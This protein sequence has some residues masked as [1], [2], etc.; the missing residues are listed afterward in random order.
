LTV[1]PLRILFRAAAGPRTGF[2]HLVRCRSLAR[3]LGVN[4]RVS[5]RGSAATRA[6][7]AL[8]GWQVLESDSDRALRAIDPQ[9]LVVDDPSQQA[10]GIWVR[11]ARRL[12][13]RVSTIH[14]LGLGYVVSDLGIDGS[15]EP[16]LSMHGGYGDLRGPAHAIL[17]PAVASLRERHVDAT[18]N[19]ILIALGGGS[20]V[21]M[22]AARLCRALAA[23][24]P[25][26]TIRVAAGFAGFAHGGGRQP[27]VHGDWI[28]AP[29]GLATELA[30][31]SV[32]VVAGGVT[33]Y[34]ACALGVPAVAVAVTPAQ[35]VTIR[36]FAAHG[37]AI[38]GGV[39]GTSGCTVEGVAA[40]VGRLLRSRASCRRLA[41]AGQRLVDGRGAFRVGTA[42]R[43]LCAFTP[44][45]VSDAA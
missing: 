34:E 8:A 40:E 7:A 12:G 39:S 27:L 29:D 37:A 4:V 38:D 32:A 41:V 43:Q 22:F 1:S 14:D 36:A 28:H 13:I 45:G 5:I 25:D 24:V 21:F 3:A 44:P 16:R 35:H 31:A 10:A 19:Q 17:D 23:E 33:L 20:H 30:A 2:G 15:I 26:A 9:L 6:A 11:R 42:L 18:P